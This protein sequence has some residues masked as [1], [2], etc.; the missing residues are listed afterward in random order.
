MT[1]VCSICV[2]YIMT[3]KFQKETYYIAQLVNINYFSI[4]KGEERLALV[5]YHENNL[6]KSCI[7]Y[8]MSCKIS[9]FSCP[10]ADDE[11]L[12]IQKEKKQE[13]LIFSFLINSSIL[14][15]CFCFFK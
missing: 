5:A 11:Y 2:V 8:P 4:K 1:I 6:F 7:R 13:T 10:H 15:R 14:C 12:G 3:W 9:P